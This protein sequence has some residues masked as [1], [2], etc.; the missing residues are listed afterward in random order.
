MGKLLSFSLSSSFLPFLSFSFI[1]SVQSLVFL[2]FLCWK[3]TPFLSANVNRN[4]RKEE[5][6]CPGTFFYTGQDANYLTCIISHSTHG[7]SVG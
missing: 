3:S 1:L 7:V 6:A 4:L 5:P 2:R